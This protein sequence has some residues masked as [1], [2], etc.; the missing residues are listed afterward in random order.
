[1]QLLFDAVIIITERWF[2]YID[3]SKVSEAMSQLTT[4]WL[5][6]K[7]IYKFLY[8]YFYINVQKTLVLIKLSE[9]H[10]KY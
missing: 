9:H 1:M 3:C 10:I 6:S 4:Q 5:A 8:I 2:R 7:F